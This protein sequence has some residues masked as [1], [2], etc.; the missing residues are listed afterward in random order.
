M[1]EEKSPK[2][3]GWRLVCQGNGRVKEGGEGDGCAAEEESGRKNI[4]RWLEKN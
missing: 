3:G 2:G 1:A 4:G